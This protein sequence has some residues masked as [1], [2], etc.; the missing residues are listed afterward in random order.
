MALHMALM[1]HELGTNANKYG[2]LSRSQGRVAITWTVEDGTLR[3]RW[4][5]RGGP[6]VRA[7]TSRGFGMTLIEQ[8]AKGEGGDAHLSLEA[9]GIIW[10]I[11]LPLPRSAASNVSQAERSA[12]SG[13]SGTAPRPQVRVVEKAVARLAGKRFLV[14]EDEPLVALD[15]VA[16]LEEAGAEMVAHVGTV[17]GRPADHREHPVRRRVYRWQPPRPVGG[18]GGGC[19]DAPHGSFPFRLRLRARK[20]A[21]L[22]QE[23]G[24]SEQTL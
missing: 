1:L 5:E 23:G 17:D 19:V 4:V 20:P 8:S 6:P 10:E 21:A 7:P 18:R 12:A 3:L 9:D 15:M 13:H 2:A 22:L 14:A 16:G 11:T 24:H